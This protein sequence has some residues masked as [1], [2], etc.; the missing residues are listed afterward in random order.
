M[1]DFIVFGGINMDLFAYLPRSP[2]EGETIEANSIEFFLGGKG[3]N[4][5]S[6][7]HL[8]LPTILCV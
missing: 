1:S 7:T 2:E 5:V 8:T 4:P 6:Y 3:A